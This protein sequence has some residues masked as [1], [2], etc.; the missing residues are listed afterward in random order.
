MEADCENR[1]TGEGFSL[2]EVLIALTVLGVGVLSVLGMTVGGL[3]MSDRSSLVREMTT[4]AETKVQ[5]ISGLAFDDPFLRLPDQALEVVHLQ[6]WATS[7]GAT[8]RGAWVASEELS[9]GEAAPFACRVRVRQF[10]LDAL[11]L[12]RRF[13]E[14]DERLPGGWPRREIQLKEI[15]VRVELASGTAAS[16][17]SKPVVSLRWVRAY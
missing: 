3:R 9:A 16:W 4:L 5:E 12:G 11:E 7:R 1:R 8:G 2:I 6:R 13:L 17:R 10:R 15:D 14:S